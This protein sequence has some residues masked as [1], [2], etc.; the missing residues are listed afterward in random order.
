MENED[1][2]GNPTGGT[3]TPNSSGVGVSTRRTTYV[4]VREISQSTAVFCFVFFAPII[5]VQFFL[6][7]CH[8]LKKRPHHPICL[9]QLLHL[10]PLDPPSPAPKVGSHVTDPVHRN[11]HGGSDKPL[12]SRQQQLQQLRWQ[13]RHHCLIRVLLWMRKDLRAH[14]VLNMV[15]E[16]AVWEVIS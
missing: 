6:R 11:V 1:G 10:N 3:Q 12:P 15:T 13:Q 14:I 16:T 9:P 7:M 8:L 2:A 4:V 5:S